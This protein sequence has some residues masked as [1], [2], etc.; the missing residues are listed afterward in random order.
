MCVCVIVSLSLF[1]FFFLIYLFVLGPSCG[2]RDLGPSP[3]MEL[4]LPALELGVLA[5]G[6]PGKSLC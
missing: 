5:T 1:F 4:R 6:L 2:L 3:E